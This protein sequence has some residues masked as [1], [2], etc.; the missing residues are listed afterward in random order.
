[1]D[2]AILSLSGFS[3]AISNRRVL[4]NL[5]FEVMPNS[6]NVLMG[7]GAAG[8]STLLRT[9]SG[10]TN[11]QPDVRISGDAQYLGKPLFS[12]HLPGIATQNPRLVLSTVHEY[13]ASALE[14]RSA[15]TRQEQ[16][17]VV[18]DWLVDADLGF[19]TERLQDDFVDLSS[20]ERRILSVIRPMFCKPALLC[21]DEPT[22][23]LSD[24]EAFG[25]V[26]LFRYLQKH[27][28]LLIVTHH[29]QYAREIADR[30]L[31][32]LEGKLIEDSPTEQFF[33]A[34]K[35]EEALQYLRTGGC[36]LEAPTIEEISEAEPSASRN[37]LPLQ[38]RAYTSE[39]R[40]PRGF[41]WLLAGWI[42]GTPKPG[43]T[44]SEEYD[45]K[46][47]QRV[48]TTWLITLTEQPFIPSSQGWDFKITHFPIPDMEGP[49]FESAARLVAEVGT[50]LHSGEVVVFHCHAGL[51][52]TGTMLAAYLVSQGMRASEAIL[53]TR[54]V[55]PRWIQSEVQET[56][57]E[58][59][60]EFL[61]IHNGD[62]P[63]KNKEHECH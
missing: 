15:L 21:L 34:P 38:P 31:L 27:T 28:A 3:V 24:E 30:V 10:L 19:L 43:V 51:G 40:G 42:G 12:G 29:Q 14:N 45:L 11:L 41:R 57:L 18:C 59:F 60:D 1:V 62:S 46:A 6:I 13:L 52:R 61:R 2:N 53:A 49:G 26:S 35:T 55:E 32:L 23:N 16:A 8:K 44:D 22:A 17:K 36:S 9:L 54:R 58:E 48:G 56:F 37:P 33:E 47:L 4:S 25:F 39:S 63:H 7:P 5:H 20:Y 50:A